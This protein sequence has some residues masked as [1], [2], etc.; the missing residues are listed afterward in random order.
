MANFTTA[1]H[2]RF[3]RQG[4]LRSGKAIVW[5]FYLQLSAL[6]P[7][8]RFHRSRKLALRQA[9]ERPQIS[10]EES[11]LRTIRPVRCEQ[12]GSDETRSHSPLR[13]ESFRVL[14]EALLLASQA[15]HGTVRSRIGAFGWL[16][17][18]SEKIQS[19]IL[20]ACSCDHNRN[21][22]NGFFTIHLQTE[23]FVSSQL[24]DA[25]SCASTTQN[26]TAQECVYIHKKMQYK[27]VCNAHI[28]IQHECVYVLPSELERRWFGVTA[29]S[30]RHARRMSPN[31][32]EPMR[33]SA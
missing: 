2:P 28:S 16:Q 14:C 30:V 33:S 25:S 4:C 31:E 13:G 12:S 29:S 8:L 22:T 15:L 19:P 23:R 21:F 1:H 11:A 5:T 17:T 7:H 3:L 32:S 26:N 27:N 18:S 20:A 9:L 10:E 6:S 24:S